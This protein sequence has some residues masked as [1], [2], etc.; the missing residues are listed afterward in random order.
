MAIWLIAASREFLIPVV[1]LPENSGGN[2]TEVA[3][4]KLPIVLS[5][6]VA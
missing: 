4:Y 2:V 6:S 5:D 3:L 1:R